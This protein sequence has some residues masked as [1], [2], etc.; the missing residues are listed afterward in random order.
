MAEGQDSQKKITVNIKTPKEKQTVE[1]E[2]DAMIKD[3]NT[4][5]KFN[6]YYYLSYFIVFYYDPLDLNLCFVF[7]INLNSVDNYFFFIFSVQRY[8]G[9]EI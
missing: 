8:S 3:V 1:I 2:E 5:I 4:I 7:E 9:Q 6:Y